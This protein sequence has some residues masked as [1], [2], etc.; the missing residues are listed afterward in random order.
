MHNLDGMFDRRVRESGSLN[1]ISMVVQRGLFCFAVTNLQF[2]AFHHGAPNRDILDGRCLDTQRVTVK[3][4]EVGQRPDLYAS[5][6]LLKPQRM[7]SAKR[8][9]V[10][11]ALSG[12]LLI[13]SGHASGTGDPVHRTL[14]ICKAY[15]LV[16]AVRSKPDLAIFV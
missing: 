13:L 3:N 2:G 15:H 5:H 8:D 16:G 10:Q 4:D 1:R 6:F 12:G 11:R 14:D 9:T 7:G